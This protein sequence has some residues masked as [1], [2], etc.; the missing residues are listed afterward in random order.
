MVEFTLQ[1]DLNT[2]ELLVIID[3]C[4]VCQIYVEGIWKISEAGNYQLWNCLL[5]LYPRF[6][7]YNFFRNG[8]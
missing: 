3:N 2:Q 6:I 4:K 7:I 1:Y 5:L 8:I